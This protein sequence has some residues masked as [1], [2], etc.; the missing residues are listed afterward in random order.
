MLIAFIVALRKKGATKEKLTF[1]KRDVVK[2][3]EETVLN[4]L[5]DMVPYGKGRNKRQKFMSTSFENGIDLYI[6]H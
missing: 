2:F 6:F 4:P 3:A 5:R 1:K